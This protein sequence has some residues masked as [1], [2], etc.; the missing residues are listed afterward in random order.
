MC[1]SDL[2]DGISLSNTKILEDI[3]WNGICVEPLPLSFNKLLNNRKCIKHNLAVSEVNGK[4]QFL[5]IDGYSEMLSGLFETYD[6][7]HLERI[8]RELNTYGGTKKIID[9]DSVRFSD[10][11]NE[12]EI[13]YISIDVEGS[14]LNVIKSIDFDKHNI[15]CISVENNYGTNEV[16]NYLNN[17]GF[18]FLRNVGAD[19]F[20]IKNK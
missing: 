12:K 1:S 20:F 17:F 2:N 19:N 13:D 8:N 18:K 7:R 5:Q 3:G 14:E 6:P 4:L 9:I 16:E 15:F 11:I 10:L